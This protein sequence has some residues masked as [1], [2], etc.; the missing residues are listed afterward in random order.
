VL[1]IDIIDTS[2]DAAARYFV[3]FASS[4]AYVTVQYPALAIFYINVCF[5]LSSLGWLAQLGAKADIV[6]RKVGNTSSPIDQ[7]YNPDHFD[8]NSD[9]NVHF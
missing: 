4:I 9:L 5:F 7:C 2:S 1:Y 6:C 3:N 8:E